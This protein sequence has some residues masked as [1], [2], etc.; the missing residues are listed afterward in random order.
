MRLDLHAAAVVV[1]AE[2]QDVDRA[3][4]GRP[5]AARGS[6]R[7]SARRTESD[8]LPRR[9][10]SAP[11]FRTSAPDRRRSRCRRCSS[12]HRL[13]TISPA[14]VSSTSA[15]ATC[16]AISSSR[17]GRCSAGATWPRDPSRTA[18]LQIAAATSAAPA[19]RPATTPVTS[20]Q[21]R[22]EHQHASVDPDVLGA[23]HAGGTEP[24][25]THAVL[26]TASARPRSRRAPTAAGSR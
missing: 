19:A 2:R 13:R 15:S 3:D 22:R 16:D 20:A 4:V 12:C 26:T 21:E 23:R 24:R 6:R 18:A 11:R 14:P 10:P 5:Q 1:G 8:R 17:T 25:Q 9:S 7:R